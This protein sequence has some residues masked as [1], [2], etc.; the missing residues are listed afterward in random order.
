MFIRMLKS[1]RFEDSGM[2][3]KGIHCTVYI[4]Y[5]TNSNISCFSSKCFNS[6]RDNRCGRFGWLEFNWFGCSPEAISFGGQTLKNV[7]VPSIV[8]TI[9]LSKPPRSNSCADIFLLNQFNWISGFVRIIIKI[10]GRKIRSP[11]WCGRTRATP[12]RTSLWISMNRW[13]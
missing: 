2:E 13:W 5:L 11:N 4:Q 1:I 6:L 8:L 3:V 7:G 9:G 12:W 10:M